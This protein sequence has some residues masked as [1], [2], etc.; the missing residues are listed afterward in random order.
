MLTDTPPTSSSGPL[1]GDAD[2][3][4][5]HSEALAD[6][7]WSAVV[8]RDAR[9]GGRFLFAVASTRIYCRPSCPA[10]RPDRSRVKFFETAADAEAAGYRPCMRCRPQ[11]GARDPAV[12][13][14]NR[15][16]AVIEETEDAPLPLAQLAARIGVSPGHLQRTFKRVTRLSPREYADARRVGRLKQRL[17]SGDS[18][19]GALYTAGYGSS[20]R[21]YESAERH[22]GMTPATYRDRGKGLRISFTIVDTVVGRMLVAATDRG[23]CAVRLGDSDGGLEETLREEFR[24]AAIARDDA[25]LSDA[26]A[27]VVSQLEGGSAAV[28][29]PLDVR[30]TAFQQR[31]WEALRRIPYG[32]TRSY[33]EIA[34]SVGRPSA[35]RAVAR[36]CASNPLAVLVP[37]HRVVKG[38]GSAGGYRWGVDRKRAI[39]EVE[40]RTGESP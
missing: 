36:A 33:G 25:R 3:S 17:Q 39:L 15:A 13:L 5:D 34:R 37:C 2:A 22:L 7:R 30:A 1:V 19:A 32:A 29:L 27:A 38:D 26:T 14:V 35:V 24:G 9:H 10:R 12:E 31:V 4:A 18:V 40:R 28:D 6:E 23:I 11:D 21:L 16:S 20:S 8:R